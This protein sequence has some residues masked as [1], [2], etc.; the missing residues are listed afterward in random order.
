MRE[1]TGEELEALRGAGESPLWRVVLDVIEGSAEVEVEIA[2]SEN[3]SPDQRTHA[4]GRASSLR[5]LHRVLGEL[6]ESVQNR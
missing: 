2:L 6:Q 5:A 4:S 3:L 1:L